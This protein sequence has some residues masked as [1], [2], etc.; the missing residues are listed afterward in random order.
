MVIK[1]ENII[2]G[3]GS[4]VNYSNARIVPATSIVVGAEIACEAS[5]IYLS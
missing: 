1:D 5:L 2:K 3:Y 4:A